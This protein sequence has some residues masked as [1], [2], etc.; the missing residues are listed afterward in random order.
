VNLDLAWDGRI[1]NEPAHVVDVS[2]GGVRVELAGSP[3]MEA[4]APLRLDLVQAALSIRIR[5][6][7]SQPA[8]SPGTWLWGA[9][10]LENDPATDTRWRSL[11]DLVAPA[12]L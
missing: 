8:L 5:R 6:V 7:W 1:A 2:Y 12:Q 11:V 10:V 4:N 9:E 3:P